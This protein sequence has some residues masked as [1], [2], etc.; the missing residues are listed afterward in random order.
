MDHASDDATA[1]I[2]S[3][4]TGSG[5]NERIPV[6]SLLPADSPRVNGE[7]I[8]HVRA[9][10]GVAVDL[11]PVLVHRKSMRVI[12]GMHRIRAAQ[13]R[14]EKTVDV[15]FFD[16]SD[17]LVFVAAVRANVSH[18]LPLSLAEREAAAVRILASHGHWSDRTVAAVA[19]LAPSTVAAIRRRQPRRLAQ[20][21]RLGRDGRVRPLSTA[22]SR[23]VAS[24][25]IA[26]RPDASL[27]EVAK[28]AGISTGTVRDVRSRM[29]RGEDPVRSRRSLAGGQ[30]HTRNG[31]DVRGSAEPRAV[32]REPARDRSV[33]LRNLRSDPSLRF[34][35]SGRDLLRWLDVRSLGPEGWEK[36]LDKV[37]AH[38]MY[39][40]A[41]LAE[42]CSERW[43]DAAEKLRARIAVV[44]QE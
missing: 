13:L 32:P 21:K 6:G 40:V 5:P 39:L 43:H 1:R 36:A 41:E 34:T 10:A 35:Q 23:R 20:Q 25:V 30:L 27:R 2:L 37:P 9:L 28:V 18:G 11:P 14:G 3:S 22:E 16:G 38:S 15:Q 33:I 29:A 12:D 4:L 26:K 24:E 31:R 17:D 7:R 8:D 19:G 42:W 44:N